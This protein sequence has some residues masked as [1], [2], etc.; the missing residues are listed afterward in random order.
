MKSLEIE[1]LQSQIREAKN[2]LE[3]EKS[4]AEAKVE[5]AQAELKVAQATADDIELQREK[6]GIA[7]SNLQLAQL[8]LDNLNELKASDPELVN[9]SQMKRQTLLVEQATAQV[10][11]EESLLAKAKTTSTN[12]IESARAGLAAAQA[13][14]RVV[15]AGS[16]IDTLNKQME[17]LVRQRNLGEVRAPRDGVVL[18]TYVQEGEAIGQRPFCRPGCSGEDH[19]PRVCRRGGDRHHSIPRLDRGPGRSRRSRCVRRPRPPRD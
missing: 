3:A 10:K 14:L 6:L 2:R 7:N 5:A 11:A 17:L 12:A 13:A 1:A 8:A 19:Q 18:K 9:D 16:S 15:E 4:A